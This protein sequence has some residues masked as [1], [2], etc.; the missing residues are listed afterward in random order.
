VVPV[1]AAL[2]N[3]VLPEVRKGA[4]AEVVA[5]AGQHDAEDVFF[6]HQ[7]WMLFPE[8]RRE[9]EGQVSYPE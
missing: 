3:E 6:I 1:A 2:V 4:V 7:I 5:E 9:F 8:F